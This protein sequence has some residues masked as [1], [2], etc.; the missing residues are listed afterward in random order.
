[1]INVA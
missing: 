1:M